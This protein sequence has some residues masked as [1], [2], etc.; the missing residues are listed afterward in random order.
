MGKQFLECK[1]ASE[2]IALIGVR[3]SRISTHRAGWQRTDCPECQDPK[4]RKDSFSIKVENDGVSYKCHRCEFSGRV[5]LGEKFLQKT[6]NVTKPS[7]KVEEVSNCL[8]T[9]HQDYLRSRGILNAALKV[10]VKTGRVKGFERLILNYRND[11]AKSYDPTPNSKFKWQQH[12]PSDVGLP[13]WG[14]VNEAPEEI[15]ITEGEWDR[16]TAIEVGY[17][18]NAAYSIPDGA[19][20]PK[21]SV[22]PREHA[23]LSCIRDDFEKLKSAKRVILALDNDAPGQCTVEAMIE[24]FG[25]W[26]CLVIDWPEHARGT[27]LDGKCKDLNEV[28]KLLGPDTVADLIKNAKPL[29]LCGVYEPKDIPKPPKRDYYSVGVH[30]RNGKD[31]FRLFKGGLSV[32]SGITNHGKTNFLFWMLA[33]LIEQYDLKVGLGTFEDEY[34]EDIVPWYGDYLFGAD[35]PENWE[36]LTNDWMQEHFRIISYQIEPLTEQAS[37]EWYLQQ[38]QAAIGRYGLDVFVLDPW[39]KIQHKRGKGEAETDYIGRALAEVKN[40]AMVNHVAMVVT[41]H[42]TKETH[43]GGTVHIPNITQLHGSM[44]WGNGSDHV[45]I[46][47]RPDLTK[48]TTCISLQ[49]VKHQTNQFR[50]G[51]GFPGASWFVYRNCRYER[52]PIETWPSEGE[53]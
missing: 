1:T 50:E 44:N 24:L 37:I 19:V 53:Y 31:L 47:F 52:K 38:C 33:Q 34:W 26:R 15:L 45:A 2:A 29:K 27:G 32:V 36:D 23:K 3:D 20:Q 43:A 25:R 28:L 22:S 40:F 11:W 12:K 16:L 35:K 48:T 18:P 41:C 46:V 30:D 13:L 21:D 5:W 6:P 9:Q 39:N 8:S 51:A 49:K 4:K 17:S 14:L 42:P 7:P 10:G